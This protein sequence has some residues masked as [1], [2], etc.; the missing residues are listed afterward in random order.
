MSDEEMTYSSRHIEQLLQCSICLDRFKT[1][2]LLP[3]QHTYCQSP[4]LEQLVNP[5]TR[6]IRCPECRADHL[7]PRGGTG[8]YPNNI[9]IMGFM[10]LP[11]LAQGVESVATT[12]HRDEGGIMP[13]KKVDKPTDSGSSGMMSSVCCSAGYNDDFSGGSSYEAP[14]VVAPPPPRTTCS[15]CFRNSR[16]SACNHCQQQLC[17]ACCRQHMEQVKVEIERMIYRIKRALPKISSAIDDIGY[18]GNQSQQKCQNAKTEITDIFERHLRDFE[19]RQRF[20]MAEVDAFLFAELENLRIQQENLEVELA[21]MASFCDS[22]ESAIGHGSR[23]TDTELMQLH[24]Q[25]Q[26][27]SDTMQSFEG[28][29]IRRAGLRQ[30]DVK[31][32]NQL[33]TDAIAAFGEVE[34]IGRPISAHI[35]NRTDGQRSYESRLAS[36]LVDLARP[37]RSLYQS[38]P[39]SRNIDTDYAL[40]VIG[41]QSPLAVSPASQRRQTYLSS[42]DQHLSADAADLYDSRSG[43]NT[44]GAVSR[45]PRRRPRR[46]HHSD[47]RIAGIMGGDDTAYSRYRRRSLG[48]ALSPPREADDLDDEESPLPLT[49][50]QTFSRDPLQISPRNPRRPIRYD[51]AFDNGSSTESLDDDN[52]ST[53]RLRPNPYPN[54]NNRTQTQTQSQTQPQNQNNSRSN[55][56]NVE[57]RNKYNQ[58]GRAIIRFGSRGNGQHE[59]T[60]PRGVAVSPIDDTI[61]VAD[62]SNHRVQ[63]FD[64]TGR[65]LRSFGS[66]GTNE[67]EF[68]CLAGIT[69]N[70]LGQVIVSDRYNHRIQVFDHNCSCITSF[71]EEGS[72][73]GQL[74]YPWGIACDNMGFIYVCDKEN[75]RIQVFQSNGNFVRGFGE[76]GSRDGEFDNPQYV[77]V[78][79]DNKIYISDS[80]NHRIQVFSMYGDFLFS[81]G[82]SGTQNGQLKYPRGVAIDSQGFVAVSDSGNNRVQ[83]FRPDG[84][85]YSMFGSWGNENGQFKAL[86]GL[87]ILANGN[88]VVSDRENHRIQIF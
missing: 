40:S 88:I 3:C 56:G 65:F 43:R 70:T 28:S 48:G 55:R 2:K 11:R 82:S 37:E 58:K 54:T 77:A 45:V 73:E 57:P 52:S 78:S 33:L 25:C 61:Y 80:S 13:T 59:F 5:R 20:L 53:S 14:I 26:E 62:S 15:G 39:T 83:I 81:F 69:V 63:V 87:A 49:R 86:E 30:I 84:T 74:N 21:S 19:A 66:Y 64:N 36:R 32:E 18:K 17:E 42:R 29:Q 27:N 75:N 47:T 16:L 7:V 1:P 50:G 44:G 38:R 60:W 8:S 67:G 9:T 4:C 51:I 35:N 6:M 68:D 85:Y 72:A 34:I 23:L 31:A 79:P 46:E 10:D 41:N 12:T 22:S 71:G 76:M 24:E